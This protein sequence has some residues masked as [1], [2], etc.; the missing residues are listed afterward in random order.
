MSGLAEGP[1]QY[2]EA[3]LQRL[4][5]EHPAIAELG[6]RAVRLRDTIVLCGEVESPERCAQIEAAVAAEF[7]DLAIRND[8]G[9]TRKN[10]PT[11]VEELT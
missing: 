7:P 2:D 6:I 3:H 4:L 9:V 1:D 11:E 5:A 10:P 8:I